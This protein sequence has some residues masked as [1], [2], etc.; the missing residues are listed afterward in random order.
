MDGTGRYALLI[1]NSR[2]DDGGLDDLKGP[3]QDVAALEAL[4]ADDAR[5][6]FAVQSLTDEPWWEAQGVAGGKRRK[7]Q[8]EHGYRI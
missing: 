8:S 5:G 6:G 1:G 3:P 2:Y 7:I 4:L